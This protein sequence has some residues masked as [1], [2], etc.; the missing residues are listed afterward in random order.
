MRVLFIGGT[1][2]ISEDSAALL[3]RR[4]HEVLVLTRGHA[5]VPGGYRAVTADRHDRGAMRAVLR[6]VRVDTVINFLGFQPADIALDADLF[7]GRIRQYLFISSTTVYAKPHAHLPLTEES[8]VGNAFSDYAR[9]KQRCEE[10]LRARTATTGFPVTIVRPSHTYGPRWI[11]NPVTSAGYTFAARLET[12][13]PV[14]VHDDGQGLWTL[15]AAADFSVGL[16]GLVGNDAALGETYHIT[17]DEVLTWNQV[18]A[19][20]ALALGVPRPAIVRIPT[21]FIVRACPE[22]APK[23]LGDKAEP[24]VFDNAKIKRAVPDFQCRTPYRDGVRAA[25]AWFRADAAR[26]AVNPAVDRIFE[27]VLSE[28][29][30]AHADTRPT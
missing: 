17:S 9:G 3:A 1:G 7:D 26:Q 11:C 8:P 6:D 21:A 19:E 10:W 4:G 30:Q 15:T 5:P 12:G 16:A 29:N 2:N 24:G 22:L 20:T 18:Y 27:H 14:F 25:V 23:L 13:R 28:W